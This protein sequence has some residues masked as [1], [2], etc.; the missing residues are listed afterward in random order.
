MNSVRGIYV[1]RIISLSIHIS[2][3]SNISKYIREV[4]RHKED[5][6]ICVANEIREAIGQEV[7]I[8]TEDLEDQE[9]SIWGNK[10]ST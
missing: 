3:V 7:N 9:K 4:K 1:A 8:T 6:L 2:N 5:K 10:R